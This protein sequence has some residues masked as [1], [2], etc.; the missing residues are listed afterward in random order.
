MRGIAKL[1]LNSLYGKMLMSPVDTQTEVV[2][3]AIEFNEFVLKFNL[4]DYNIIN[5]NKVLVCGSVKGD[6]KVEKINKPRQLGAFV[7]AYSRRIMLFYM[8]KIDPELKS[9]IFTYT[10]TDSLHISGEAYFELLKQGL[11]KTKQEAKLGYLCSDIKNEGVI[12]KEINLAP[13]TYLYES[14]GNQDDIKTTMK[15]KGIPKKHLKEID[16]E[17]HGRQIEFCGLKKKTTKLTKEDREKGIALFSVCNSK[18]TRTFMK[19]VWTNMTFKDNQ[20]YPFGYESG[21]E[22]E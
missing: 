4:V 12:L 8:K 11:I 3:N 1:L 6:R 15:C 10:D 14:I 9:S 22:S 17:C 19:N 13:K 16:Y 5:D 2:N 18:Q 7:T 20:Y 21:T